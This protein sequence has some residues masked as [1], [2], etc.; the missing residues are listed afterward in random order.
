MSV[1]TP[2]KWLLLKV[3]DPENEKNHYR[4]FAT[5]S[6]SYLDGASWKLSSGCLDK[7]KLSNGCWEIK[8]SSGSLYR[9]HPFGEGLCGNWYGILEELVEIYKEKGGSIEVIDNPDFGTYDFT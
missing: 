8:Q 3:T 7:P 4:I 1:Y 2:N 9:L 6:G 5:W